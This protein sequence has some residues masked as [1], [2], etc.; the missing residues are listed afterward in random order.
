MSLAQFVNRKNLPARVVKKGGRRREE[1]RK[2]EKESR[3][4]EQ[5]ESRERER[6]ED[7]ESKEKGGGL[8]RRDKRGK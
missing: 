8:R 1:K 2:R 5:R 3:E 4:R 6:A 7:G